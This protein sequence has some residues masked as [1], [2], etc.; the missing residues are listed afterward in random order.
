TGP[1]I[2][3]PW[4]NMAVIDNGATASLFV[5]MAGFDLPSADVT[6][7]KTGYPVTV[8]KSTVLRIGLSV[9]AGGP[10]AITS[11]TIIASGLSARAD[12]D[13]FMIGPTGLALAANGT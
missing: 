6:D 12:K 7:P 1:N 3:G 13:V 10:P 8:R 2:N 4:G 5:S 11:Q 9:P